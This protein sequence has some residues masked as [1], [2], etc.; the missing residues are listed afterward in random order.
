MRMYCVTVRVELGRHD[1]P[2]R[3]P[4]SSA[5]VAPRNQLARVVGRRP[6]QC[7]ARLQLRIGDDSVCVGARKSGQA[8]I[9]THL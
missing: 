2:A 6:G 9:E 5:R 7:G 3:A 8:P 4:T 1:D